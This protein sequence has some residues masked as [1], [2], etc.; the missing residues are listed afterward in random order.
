MP[1]FKIWTDKRSNTK[2]QSSSFTTLSLPCFNVFREL[3][4]FKG[5]KIVPKNIDELL[6]YRG[7][8]YWIMDDGSIQNKGLHLNIYS[9]SDEDVELLLKTLRVKFLLKCSIHKHKAGN[10]IYIW[11]ESMKALR[12]SLFE[13][14]HKDMLYK[15]GI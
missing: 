5:K 10:R 9:F 13:Y 8:A 11:E 12:I 1:K 4:Y 7:L 15:M 6:T 3:F 14:T 2:Y